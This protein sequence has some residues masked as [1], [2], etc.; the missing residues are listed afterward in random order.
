MFVC[1]STYNCS[2]HFS[3]KK[4]R[5]DNLEQQAQALFK[6]WFVDFDPFKDGKF[7]DSEL[8]M[9]PEG[10]KI[11]TFSDIIVSTLGGDWGKEINQGN[12]SKKVFCIRG[13]DIPNIKIGNRGSMP[14]RYILEKNYQSKALESGDLVVEISGGSPTQST[15]RV[16]KVSSELLTKYDNS[17]ICTNFCKAIKPILDYSIYIYYM[18][19]CL[20][21]QGVMFSYENGTTG[22]KNFDIN[23]FTQKELI[24]IPPQEIACEFAKIV[25]C[26]YKRVQFNGIESEKLSNLRDSI[27]PKLM[28]GELKIN[29]LNC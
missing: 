6:S 4:G 25:E 14:I 1:N 11:G 10:W 22:I 17:I 5:N 19:E 2:I 18:W 27:L 21:K 24:I 23:G 3:K 9:I 26:V 8:G 7:V 13:A 12:Y 28:S 15:G 16:C 29:D 20:Y